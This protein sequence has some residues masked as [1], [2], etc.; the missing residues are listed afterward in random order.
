LGFGGAD[1]FK[2]S[3]VAMYSS[4]VDEIVWKVAVIFQGFVDVYN[5]GESAKKRPQVRFD[6]T[7]YYGQRIRKRGY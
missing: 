4:R 5:R 3:I 6:R 2:F 1:D 7:I